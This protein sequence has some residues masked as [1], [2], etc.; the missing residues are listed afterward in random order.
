MYGLV[1]FVVPMGCRFCFWMLDWLA[2][3][4]VLGW[5]FWCRV[6][7]PECLVMFGDLPFGD[8]LACILV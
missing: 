7:I 6:Y 4:L 2:G 3:D 5:W 1:C 8:W